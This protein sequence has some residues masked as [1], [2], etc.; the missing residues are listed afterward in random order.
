MSCSHLILHASREW[1]VESGLV[2]V[3]TNPFK[4]CLKNPL[5]KTAMFSFG[6]LITTR[7]LWVIRFDSQSPTSSWNPYSLTGWRVDNDSPITVS[8]AYRWI[9]DAVQAQLQGQ[10]QLR[11]WEEAERFT[12]FPVEV[13]PSVVLTY[14]VHK[15]GAGLSRESQD[16][17]APGDY[18][19]YTIGTN[20]I[21]CTT[22]D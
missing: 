19:L 12:L 11:P 3:C 2:R 1:Q 6:A 7:W 8:T 16:V 14:F 17:I 21:L 9:T 5:D 22:T 4:S 15:N 20:T 13:R 10:P 18:G